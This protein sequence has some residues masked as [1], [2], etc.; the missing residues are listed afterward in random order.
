MGRTKQTARKTELLP[1]KAP[2]PP[3]GATS[4]ENKTSGATETMEFLG[5]PSSSA[6]EAGARPLSYSGVVEEGA[7]KLVP[8]ATLRES[9]GDKKK[10]GKKA[11]VAP[12]KKT[13]PPNFEELMNESKQKVSKLAGTMKKMDSDAFEESEEEEEELDDDMNDDFGRLHERVV[14][15]ARAAPR[16][17]ETVTFELAKN[18]TLLDRHTFPLPQIKEVFS[19]LHPNNENILDLTG[20]AQVTDCVL[21]G[22]LD[23]PF[24]VRDSV[25][26]VRLTGCHLVTDA[27]VEFLAKGFH[28]LKKLTLA[29]CPKVTEAS[30][31]VLAQKCD[32]LETLDI[33]GTNAA[34]LPRKLSDLILVTDCSPLASPLPAEAKTFPQSSTEMSKAVVIRREGESTLSPLRLLQG[35]TEL[36]SS[37]P[38]GFKSNLACPRGVTLNVVEC[39]QSTMELFCHGWGV[40]VIPSE[41]SDKT[42]VGEEA[43]AILAIILSILLKGGRGSFVVLGMGTSKAGGVPM[44][45][46]AQKVL[47]AAK[48][49]ASAPEMNRTFQT[50][51]QSL[52]EQLRAD[53]IERLKFRVRELSVTPLEV[54]VDERE[55]ACKQLKDQL[56][57][58]STQNPEWKC[59]CRTLGDLVQAFPEKMCK[60]LKQGIHTL[61]GVARILQQGSTFKSPLEA[62]GAVLHLTKM[63]KLCSYQQVSGR[64][65]YV[66]TS[67][68]CQLLAA[69]FDQPPKTPNRTTDIT[70]AD[71]TLVMTLEELTERA[72]KAKVTV[73]LVCQVIGE[74]RVLGTRGLKGDLFI[75]FPCLPSQPDFSLDRFSPAPSSAQVTYLLTLPVPVPPHL[76]YQVLSRLTAFRWPLHLW[77]HGLVIQHGIVEILITCEGDRVRMVSQ[78][79]R[80]GG[81]EEEVSDCG[82]SMLWQCVEEYKLLVDAQFVSAGYLPQVACTSDQPKPEEVTAVVQGHSIPPHSGE[83]HCQFC[84]DSAENLDALLRKK[85]MRKKTMQQKL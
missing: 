5:A 69:L 75:P 43:K 54:N 10:K 84:G 62:Q 37:L 68:M 51:P 6:T 63:G 16:S 50:D 34:I 20:C 32:F 56:S 78:T 31:M 4:A 25:I 36:A 8:K 73:E 66:S 47:E 67:F 53:Q 26:G 27:G 59:V 15:K 82:Q 77:R 22:M 29:G 74:V 38:L 60:D 9:R 83:S 45:L 80:L 3:V 39:S 81:V 30:L 44:A 18:L 85:E 14:M 48:G 7:Q 17:S 61:S 40:Y 12:S 70:L 42:R 72:A 24:N 23:L 11:V 13:V 35:D 2:L 64:D 52:A 28:S 19:N 65:V 76:W 1:K 55:N 79:V 58:A 71:E 57:S 49:I 41:L 33:V 21:A 46:V